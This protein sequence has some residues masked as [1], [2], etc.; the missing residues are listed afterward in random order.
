MGYGELTSQHFQSVAFGFITLVLPVIFITFALSITLNL[1]LHKTWNR[2]PSN[3]TFSFIFSFAL[4]GGVAGVI[5]GASMEA[6]VGAALAAILALVSSLLAYLFGQ[7]SLR[8][9][10]PV[11]PI[12]ITSLL[13]ST[14]VG[15]VFG[16]S[17]RTQLLVQTQALEW[18][19]F[20]N[21]QV[22]APVD[23][24]KRL[25][26]FRKCMEERTFDRA[27]EDCAR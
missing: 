18:E 1:A 27:I 7:V 3:L 21:E 25:S 24:E 20:Q 15:I 10:R 22:I 5:S 8:V 6:I 14:L 17:R 16:G 19:K 11:I 23:K 26:L 12:A 2:I 9:W 4:V 13:A